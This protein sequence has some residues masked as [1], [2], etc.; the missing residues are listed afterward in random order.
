LG[1]TVSIQI[2]TI[3]DW[4]KLKEKDKVFYESILENNIVLYGSG[5]P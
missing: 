4:Q 3:S 2:M 1:K 5:L